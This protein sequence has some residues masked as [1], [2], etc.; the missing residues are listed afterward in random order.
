MSDCMHTRTIITDLQGTE[1][2]IHKTGSTAPEKKKTKKMKIE[3]MIGCYNFLFPIFT[4][5]FS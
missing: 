5:G 3:L 1:Y 4:T 2:L